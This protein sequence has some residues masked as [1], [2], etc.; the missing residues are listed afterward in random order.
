MSQTLKPLLAPFRIGVDIGGTFTDL[1]MV[2]AQGQLR[3]E[4]VLTTPHDP[5]GKRR[6]KRHPRY[7]LG[8]QRADRT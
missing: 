4:K 3:N 8:R 2:D 6:A 7:D 5:S 1:V